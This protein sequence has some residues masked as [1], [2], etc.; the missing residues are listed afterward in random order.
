METMDQSKFSCQS[1]GK[2]YKWKPEFAGRK[3][4]CKCGFVMT[5][6]KSA[7]VAPKAKQQEEDHGPDLDALYELAAEEKTVR[8]AGAVQVGLS[9]PSCRS[10]MEPGAT[11][12]AQCGFNLKTGAKATAKKGGA[13]GI[14]AGVALAGAGGGGVA[15]AS[16]GPPS[17]FGAYAPIRKGLK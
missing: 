3:V 6:P 10:A 16:G 14:P 8:K 13:G 11:M 2:S 7:P 4:K 15:V 17:A 12:C 9:C 5:A 1:C